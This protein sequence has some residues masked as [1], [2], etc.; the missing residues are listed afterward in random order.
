MFVE[1]LNERIILIGTSHISE[2]SVN[3]VKYMIM[4]EDPDCVGV[5]LCEQRFNALKNKNKWENMSVPDVIREG[6]TYLLLMNIILSNYQ[7]RLGAEFGITPGSEMLKAV[8]L[9]EEFDKEILLMD[10]D[11]QVT[12]KRSWNAMSL[13]EKLTFILYIFSGFFEEVDENI[14]EDLKDKDLLNEALKEIS[15]EVPGIKKALI[16]ERNEYIAMN[17]LERYNEGKKIV[18][19]VGAGHLTGLKKI[20]EEN[21]PKESSMGRRKTLEEIPQQRSKMKIIA[22]AVPAVFVGLV[23]Y[24]FYTRGVSFTLTM[25]LF[26]TLINGSLSALGVILALGHPLSILT[27]LVA[28]PVT[29]LNPA[30]A[31]GWFAGLTEAKMRTPMVKDFEDLSHLERVRDYWKNN[32]TRILLVVAFANIGSVIGTFIALPYL[33]SL[34]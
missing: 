24:G 18:A 21:L 9:A 10:R 27:A 17:I 16:D 6:K 7:S 23:I 8:E 1:K 14:I 19:V 32:V 4:E 34:F 25:L 3:L 15:E 20:I 31:A 13:K 11:I 29:S 2:E 26:W 5:E 30:L 22:Y 33:L 12:M 28:A